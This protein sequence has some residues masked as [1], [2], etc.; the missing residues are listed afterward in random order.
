MFNPPD[1]INQQ[2]QAYKMET[3]LATLAM[4][5]CIILA[6]FLPHFAAAIL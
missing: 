6:L 1:Q 4:I 2:Q 5:A 3:F